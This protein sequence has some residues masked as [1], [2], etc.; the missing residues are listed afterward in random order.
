MGVVAVLRA[1]MHLGVVA[2][3]HA[4]THLCRQQHWIAV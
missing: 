1:L 4:L 3:L 2:V